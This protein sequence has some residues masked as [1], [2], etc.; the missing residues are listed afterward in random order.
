MSDT[1]PAT[2]TFESQF[3]R[4]FT[5]LAIP[6]RAEDAP[7]PDLLVLNGPRWATLE[8]KK[9]PKAKEQPNQPGWAW[10]TL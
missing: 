8:C 4:E 3:A 7:N 5:E 2:V 1:V 6:W 9:G 10:Q